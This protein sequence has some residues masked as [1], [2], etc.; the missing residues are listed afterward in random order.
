MNVVDSSA[1]LEYFAN[2]TLASTFAEPIKDLAN[3]IV[4][5]IT[6]VEVHKKAWARHGLKH[7]NECTELMLTG[8]LVSLDLPVA[9]DASAVVRQYEL[10]M[11]DSIVYA[12]A[13]LNDATTWTCDFDF[14][15]LPN[16]RYFD[17][18]GGR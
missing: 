14:K 17:K 10:P 8:R 4:P 9:L 7:A 6:I 3:L 5:S 16:V 1:W 15:D 11:A 13:R 12:T 18:R 2:T